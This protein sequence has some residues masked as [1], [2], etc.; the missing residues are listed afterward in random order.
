[1]TE[2]RLEQMFDLVCRGVKTVS[3]DSESVCVWETVCVCVRLWLCLAALVGFIIC[4]LNLCRI[5]RS[6]F[7]PTAA[8]YV[9][10]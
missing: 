3:T 1:M 10:H 4:Y 8:D 5:S 6:R 9:A 2:T 7:G